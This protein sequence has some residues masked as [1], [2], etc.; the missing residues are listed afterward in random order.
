MD[1]GLAERGYGLVFSGRQR[2]ALDATAAAR[3][4]T[5]IRAEKPVPDLATPEKS[6]R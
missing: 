1:E 3:K 5:D 2:E 4:K 6:P